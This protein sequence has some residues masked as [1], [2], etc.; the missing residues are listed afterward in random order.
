MAD[1]RGRKDP[2]ALRYARRP[3]ESER[4]LS[5]DHMPFLGM[6][7]NPS[8]L[9]HI[10]LVESA[11]FRRRRCGW[12]SQATESIDEPDQHEWPAYLIHPLPNF[13]RL[14]RS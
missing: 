6:T 7:T 2:P 3:C 5:Q 8:T 12:P 14:L 10:Y 4:V 1:P 13:G 9:Q 11:R